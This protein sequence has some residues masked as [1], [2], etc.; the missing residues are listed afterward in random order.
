MK[1]IKVLFVED[2][3]LLRTLFEDTIVG[4]QEDYKDFDFQIETTADLKS[5]LAY[6]GE[7]PAPN[8]IVLDLRLPTGETEE[9]GET[10]EKENGISILEQVK[11]NSKFQN[12][13]VIVFTNLNDKETEYECNKLGADDFMIKAKVLPKN[14]LDAII[15]L[16]K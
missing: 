7:K 5:A 3:K 15:R 10:P 14:L 1:T 8:V 4:F 16:V 9:G 12:T 6:L 13:P 2:E 11:A